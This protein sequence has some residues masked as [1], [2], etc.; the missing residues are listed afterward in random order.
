MGALDFVFLLVHTLSLVPLF[1]LDGKH[2]DMALGINVVKLCLL[3][4]HL[5]FL[6]RLVWTKTTANTEASIQIRRN[7]CLYLH[8]AQILMFIV[9]TVY[10]FS[11]AFN[12]CEG[13]VQLKWL[14]CS[15]NFTASIL[16]ELIGY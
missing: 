7:N 11:L 6:N 12:T 3:L 2:V 16:L 4:I 8:S 1:L 10:D 9:S 15:R 13:D 14:V 5:F